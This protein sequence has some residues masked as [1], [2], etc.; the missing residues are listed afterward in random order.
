[1]VYSQWLAFGIHDF[2]AVLWV[3]LPVSE[4]ILE[5]LCIDYVVFS[6]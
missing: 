6:H 5:F 3:I 4:P 2:G 1:M